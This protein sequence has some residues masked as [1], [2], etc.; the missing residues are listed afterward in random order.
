MEGLVNVLIIGLAACV[1]LPVALVAVLIGFSV[2]NN[3]K[4]KERGAGTEK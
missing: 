3:R 4:K 1:L 2:F